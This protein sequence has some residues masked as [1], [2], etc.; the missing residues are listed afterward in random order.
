MSRYWEVPEYN[1][2]DWDA[3]QFAMKN[4]YGRAYMNEIRERF[5]LSPNF[6]AEVTGVRA[7]GSPATCTVF[8]VT[9]GFSFRTDAVHHKGRYILNGFKSSTAQRAVT[10]TYQELSEQ[11]NANEIYQDI[12]DAAKIIAH[13]KHIEVMA[14]LYRGMSPAALE[15]ATD[16]IWELAASDKYEELYAWFMDHG[17]KNIPPIEVLRSN[18]KPSMKDW[19]TKSGPDGWGHQ[20]GL[21][22]KINWKAR[23]F[24][25]YGWSSDD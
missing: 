17:F 10:C 24:E 2:S 13:E 3:Q 21:A 12:Q 23:N 11:I 8:V 4:S 14:R 9:D 6:V 1:M 7:D 19:V 20:C 16:R 15:A 18:L 22:M 5:G 25:S